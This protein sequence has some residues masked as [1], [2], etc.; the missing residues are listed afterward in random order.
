MSTEG[1]ECYLPQ[2]NLDSYRQDGQVAWDGWMERQ[3]RRQERERFG[4]LHTQANLLTK[5]TNVNLAQ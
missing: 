2:C 5:V 3:E 4:L 1:F